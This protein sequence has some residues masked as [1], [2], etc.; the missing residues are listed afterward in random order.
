MFTSSPT[1]TPP[2]STLAIHFTPSC[3]WLFFLV[4]VGF[5]RVHSV[6]VDGHFNAG[7]RDVL[8][9]EH[10]CAAQ[11]AERAAHRGKAQM[12]YGKLRGGVL[13]VNLPCGCGRPGGQREPH[14]HASNHCNAREV[15]VH[16]VFP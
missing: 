4:A 15:P 11:L 16:L 7:F 13:R 3:C 10:H 6:Y 9:I 14:G 2:L 1:T 5:A 8:V 12:T